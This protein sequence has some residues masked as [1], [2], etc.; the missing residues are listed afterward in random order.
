MRGLGRVAFEKYLSL[1][2]LNLAFLSVS[3]CYLTLFSTNAIK[4]IF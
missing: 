4:A 1:R 2:F 3:P